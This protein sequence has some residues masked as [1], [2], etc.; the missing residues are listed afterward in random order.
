MGT[1][2]RLQRKFNLPLL[3]FYGVGNILG[4]GIYVLIGKVAAASGE[5]VLL[6][7]L[8]ASGIAALS[9]FSYMELTDRFP[10][11]AGA[12][13]YVHHAYKKRPLT[14][15]VG[16]CMV[17]SAI[18]S[19]AALARGFAGYF[20]QII[21][22]PMTLIAVLVIIAMSAVAMWGIDATA[23][24]AALFTVIEISGLIAIIWF[25]RNLIQASGAQA[26][27][28]SMSE[29]GIGG[30]LMGAFLAFYA[31]IGFE[32]MVN[33][34]E[35]VKDSKKTMPRAILLSLIISTIMYLLVV[36]VSTRAVPIS[37]LANSD[38]PLALVFGTVSG[39]DPV[40]L[41]FVGL[42]ATINGILVQI[43]MA[44]RMLYG[45]ANKGWI[46]ERLANVHIK[47]KTP[48][49][50]IILV[51]SVM[52]VSAAAF[53]LVSL[54]KLTSFIVLTVFILINTSLLIVKKTHPKQ[55]PH[56]HVPKWVPAIGAATSLAL[57]IW[58]LV[59]FI[60]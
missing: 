57:I 6:A 14:L 22:A 33:V 45:M 4:A 26:T 20:E 50:A 15:F 48:I 58:Q 23:K 18:I 21:P 39:L 40:I 12:A 27:L 44:S 29:F 17:L 19:S 9:A 10:A 54:A 49:L 52:L 24:L 60:N 46:N 34:A 2:I 55:R 37:Q 35:E 11:S 1:I 41:V 47:T 36:V 43:T 31:F 13:V 5:S 25:G 32:D 53:N 28:F 3:T 30:V 16:F 51:T 7:F 42:A 38:S 56:N 8:L 59:E